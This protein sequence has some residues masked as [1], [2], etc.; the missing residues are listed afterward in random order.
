M[1]DDDRIGSGLFNW[2]DLSPLGRERLQEPARWYSGQAST[3]TS[4]T[5]PA[6]LTFG[7]VMDAVGAAAEAIE[8][9]AYLSKKE[10]SVLDE[11]L[12]APAWA[13][14]GRD[15]DRPVLGIRIEHNPA[16]PAGTIMLPEHPLNVT[17]AHLLATDVWEAVQPLLSEGGDESFRDMV[18]RQGE[19]GPDDPFCQDGADA[20]IEMLGDQAEGPVTDML[21]RTLED[22]D[23]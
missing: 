18:A 23:G 11:L 20:V 22:A 10:R 14:Q 3:E 9:C 4:E 16:L 19:A 12:E 8:A 13:Q 21:Q 17:G 15:R 5:H 1:A 2:D 6:A 7:D